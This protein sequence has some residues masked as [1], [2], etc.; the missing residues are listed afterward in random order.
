MWSGKKIAEKTRSR[1]G[2]KPSVPAGG[3]NVNKTKGKV[4][5]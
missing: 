1:L 5:M 3:N 2:G 4:H